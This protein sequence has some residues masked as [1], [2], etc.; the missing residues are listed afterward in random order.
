M[1]H[2]TDHGIVSSFVFDA[3]TLSPT[4]PTPEPTTRSPTVPTTPYPTGPTVCI[5]EDALEWRSYG[6]QL[7][8]NGNE[9]NLK[10]LS[11]FGF[12]TTNYNLY[13]LDTH[14]MD[15]Y[16]QWMVDHVE[17]SGCTLSAFCEMLPCSV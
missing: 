11:W 9:F 3:Q 14:D 17:C 4:V 13:G 6:N 5:D 16:L 1:D 12:E 15:W 7:M 2:G 10:G 8:L